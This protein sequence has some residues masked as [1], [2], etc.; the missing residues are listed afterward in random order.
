[1]QEG[2]NQGMKVSIRKFEKKDISDKVRWINDPRN[3]KYLHYDLPLNVLKTEEWFEKNKN[4]TERYDAIIEVDGISVGLVGLLSIDK[5]NRKAEYYIAIGEVL[6]KGKG[7]ALQATKK[8]LE[9]AFEELYLQRVYLYTETENIAAQRLFHKIGFRKEGCIKN[10]LFSK[11]HWVDRFVYGMTKSDYIKQKGMTPIQLLGE[12]C[13][14]QLFVKREDLIPYSFGGNKARKA[15]LFFEQIDEGNYDCVV[16]YGSSHSNHCRVVANKARERKIPCYII[17]PEESSDQTYNS[18]LMGIL[19]ASIITVPIEKVSVTIENKINELKE[20]GYHPYFI[21][22]GGHGNIGTKAYVQCYDEIVTY[23]IE[24]EV[25]FDYIFLATGTGT[26]Q[27][28]LVCGQLMNEDNEKKII[29]ISIARKNPRGM[30]VVIDSIK[31]YCDEWAEKFSE[32][33]IIDKT[34]F[35]DEYVGDGYGKNDVEVNN[36][37]KEVFVNYGIPM[38][39]TYTAKAFN[40]MK[41]HIITNEIKDKKILFVH[42]GGTPLFFEDIGKI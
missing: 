14:N 20:G 35:I 7:V 2:K 39:S 33:D 4:R 12:F 11:G 13:G 18:K 26:T 9:Y 34:I 42:T 41:K 1:M 17:S 3:N 5:K 15:A 40:G 6:F 19:G 8:I 28:G 21:A 37:I 31:D 16:T 10:D 27:A 25:K 22:G 29:G 24:N 38:D 30:N 36:L 32:S 23:E